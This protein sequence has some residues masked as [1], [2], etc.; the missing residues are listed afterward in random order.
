VTPQQVSRDP[1]RGQLFENMVVS[2]IRKQMLNQGRDARLSFLR[3]EKGFEVDLIISRGGDI[4]PIEIK[5]AMTYHDSFTNNLHKLM[6]V[7]KNIKSSCLVY[8]G[9]LNIPMEDDEINVGVCN[10][11]EFGVGI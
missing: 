3:T 6:K 10:F 1:L 7:E 4:Q 2:D 5:S 9:D 11:R 8:D